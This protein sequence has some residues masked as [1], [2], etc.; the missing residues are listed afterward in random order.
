RGDDLPGMSVEL[1]PVRQ[2]PFGTIASHAIGYVG[3]I[4]QS[5]YARLKSKGYTPNDT[6]GEEGLEMTY[7]SLLRGRPGGRQIKVNSAGQAVASVS[8]FAAVS[9]DDLALTLDWKIKRAAKTAMACQIKLIASLI[10]HRVG[11]S[12]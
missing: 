12:A 7:D 9:G 10:G 3:Q 5:Q 2:Y 11:G 8:D 1:V 4:S 6:I